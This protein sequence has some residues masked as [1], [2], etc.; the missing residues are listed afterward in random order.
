MDIKIYVRGQTIKEP[1]VY[2]QLAPGSRNF[3]NFIFDLSEDWD[4]LTTYAQFSQNG[5]AYNVKLDSN[6]SA[7]L[8]AEITS[9]I[10]TLMIFGSGGEDIVGTT[11]Y[12]TFHV[13]KNVFIGSGEIPGDDGSPGIIYFLSDE[14]IEKIA[15]QVA[16]IIEPDYDDL[17]NKPSINGVI[18]SGNKSLSDLGVAAASDVPTKTS[19]L[20]NDSGF[21]TSA[22]VS[23]VNGNTGAVVLTAS[24]VG[25]IA[26]PSSPSIGDIVVYANNEWKSKSPSSA[27]IH[28]IPAGG[29]SGYVLKKLSGTDYDV[30]WAAE[31]GGGGGTSDYDDLTNKPKINSVTLSGNNSL[32]DL[33]IT[34]PTPEVFFAVYGTS[35]VQD[36]ENALNANKIVFC[37]IEGQYDFEIYPLAYCI[38]EQDDHYALFERIDGDTIHVVECDGSTWST[39]S[40]SFYQFPSGGIPKTDL[41]NGVQASL[42]KADSALQSFTETDP[43]VPSWAKAANKPSYSASEVGAVASSQ[44]VA[45]AGEFLVVGNDGNVTTVTMT[46]WQGG[47]Y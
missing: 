35:S 3:V 45:H 8:P 42:G 11:N 7:Y 12:L 40:A 16:Q 31:S 46:A 1:P 20:Q 26:A 47:S 17:T 9:G 33:G 34:S 5:T 25:S 4:N 39:D 36:I 23:S 24:D 28:S 15:E 22:P 44:G 18:L 41:D 30:A 13:G 2:T 38:N 6:N 32:S 10:A 27:G 19:D 37:V 29:S 43:T 14:D 21:I